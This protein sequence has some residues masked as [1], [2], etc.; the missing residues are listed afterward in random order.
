MVWD[1]NGHLLLH[2]TI[3][4]PTCLF[5]LKRVDHPQSLTLSITEKQLQNSQTTERFYKDTHICSH[6]VHCFSQSNTLTWHLTLEIWIKKAQLKP[7]LPQF[8]KARATSG[9]RIG[10]FCPRAKGWSEY[11]DLLLGCKRPQLGKLSSE[12]GHSWGPFWS[13]WGQKKE[14]RKGEDFRENWS[15][16]TLLP[17]THEPRA[18]CGS[19]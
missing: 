9:S 15:Y 19:R 8:Y 6:T 12:G 18:S 7:I 1:R 16:Q 14:W 11:W 4:S 10:L 3:G 17:L 5:L 13:S 2:T